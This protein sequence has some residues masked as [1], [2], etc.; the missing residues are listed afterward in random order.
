[1]AAADQAYT[2][3]A[4]WAS[5]FAL[6]FYSGLVAVEQAYQ[7]YH[8]GDWEASRKLLGQPSSSTQFLDLFAGM[9]RGRIAL[10]QDHGEQAHADATAHIRYA[11]DVGS[12]EDFYYGEALEARCHHA[13]G[14]DVEA[15][16]TTERFLARWH[17]G[18]A[19]TSRSLELCELAPILGRQGRHDDIRRAALLLPEA[20]RWRDALLLTAEE[21]YVE[22]AL[23]YAEIGS[24]PLAADA[25]LLAAH[26]ATA[27]GRPS[28]AA[29]HARA[30]L[31][32]AEQTGAKLYEHQAAHFL[33]AT[34]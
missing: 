6:S 26:R 19:H 12:D 8:R 27:E 18:G 20:C 16:A 22:A 21:R 14:K 25:H 24:R 33:Q 3:A 28:E 13:Q 10:A 2:S 9:V 29:Q 23:L 17:D 5:R 34:A 7:A 31:A 1:M 30:V 15:H 11:T 32:F 4:R